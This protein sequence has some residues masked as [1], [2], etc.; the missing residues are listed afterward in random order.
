MPQQI[1]NIIDKLVAHIDVRM[2]LASS[3]WIAFTKHVYPEGNSEVKDPGQKAAL[4]NNVI[5]ILQFWTKKVPCLHT[6]LN[7]CFTD[8][9]LLS[10]GTKSVM[11]R[12]S[13]RADHVIIENVYCM[14]TLINAG[15]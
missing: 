6:D 3:D 9:P 15:C 5:L 11:G 13:K 7:K 14:Y 8:S 4:L 12:Q 10:A 1:E 2:T